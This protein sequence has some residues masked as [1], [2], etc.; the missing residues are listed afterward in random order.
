MFY[1]VLCQLPVHTTPFLVNN[2]IVFKTK[3]SN[4]HF[5]QQLGQFTAFL[6]R[7]CCGSFT[8]KRS[9]DY[10]HS[11]LISSLT[12]LEKHG[13][14]SKQS[15]LKSPVVPPCLH[16]DAVDLGGTY[17]C[18]RARSGHPVRMCPTA[19]RSPGFHYTALK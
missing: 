19:T 3:R 13:H 11:H 9:Q 1:L 12:Q 7:K 10:S 2:H 8:W 16:A 17:R 18:L 5:Q 6:K 15:R 14:W 4:T